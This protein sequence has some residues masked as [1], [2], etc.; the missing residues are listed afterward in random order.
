LFPPLSVKTQLIA[1]RVAESFLLKR[2]EKGVKC[3]ERLLGNVKN[4]TRF[5]FYYQI[6]DNLFPNFSSVLQE[7]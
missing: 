7:C 4:V 2:M 3:T 1:H 6:L 5:D